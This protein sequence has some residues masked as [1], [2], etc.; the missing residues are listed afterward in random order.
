MASNMV[1]ADM[2]ELLSG[3]TMQVTTRRETKLR[4][5]VGTWLVALGV[6]VMGC[7]IEFDTVTEAD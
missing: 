7:Q 4:M 2:G 1:N 3:I 6:R 5:R